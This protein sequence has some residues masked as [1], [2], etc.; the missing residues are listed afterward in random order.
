MVDDDNFSFKH[1][2]AKLDQIVSI[3]KGHTG[4]NVFMHCYTGE[5][6][7]GVAFAAVLKCMTNLSYDSIIDNLKCHMG[8]SDNASEYLVKTCTRKSSHRFIHM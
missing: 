5:H 4:G 8:Y 6:D 2:H 1:I 3:V 7:T